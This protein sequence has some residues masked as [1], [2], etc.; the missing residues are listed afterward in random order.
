MA[1]D[2]FAQQ[3]ESNRLEES[4]SS[5]WKSQSRSQFKKTMNGIRENVGLPVFVA[6]LSRFFAKKPYVAW[7]LFGDEAWLQVAPREMKTVAVYYP[8]VNRGGAEK[9]TCE[10][11]R[12]WAANGLRVVIFTDEDPSDDDYVRPGEFP[13]IVLSPDTDVRMGELSA[14]MESYSIDAFVSCNWL[15]A[16]LP[17]DMML[18]KGLGV[19]FVVHAHNTVRTMFFN[20]NPL[21]FSLEVVYRFLDGLIVLTRADEEYWSKTV[22]NVWRTINPLPEPRGRKGMTEDSRTIVW[23]GRLSEFDKQPKKALDIMARVLER[24]GDARLIMVGADAHGAIP[25]ELTDHAATLGISD[26]VEFAGWQ[27]DVG[28]YYEQ[29]S[30]FLMTSRYEGFPLTLS[31]A[32]ASSVPC[33]LFEL[34]YLELVQGDSGVVQVPKDDHCSAA[35]AICSLLDDPSLMDKSSLRERERI[36]KLRAFDRSSQWSEVFS[37]IAQGSAD[38][39]RQKGN[40]L[41]RDMLFDA[42][43]DSLAKCE[44]E[45]W[46]Q[47][48]DNAAVID[49]L[50]RENRR[51]RESEARILNSKTWKAGSA[52]AFIPRKVNMLLRRGAGE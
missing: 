13:R 37:T 7:R 6:A 2:V 10:L 41:L 12:M 11:A 52:I 17:W 47:W 45:L 30:V 24:N 16:N 44:W 22:P 21:I 1:E 51:L 9:V 14:A 34:P 42:H 40:Y 31:E 50:D 15:G 48:K 36:S 39:S 49:A 20:A 33:V 25:S 43:M 3:S 27:E 32:M 23:V 35:D 26:A 46:R 28:R 5:A 38:R 29:A 18:C 19:P 8:K 4:I